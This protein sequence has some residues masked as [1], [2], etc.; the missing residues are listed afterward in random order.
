MICTADGKVYTYLNDINLT[1][2]LSINEVVKPTYSTDANGNLVLTFGGFSEKDSIFYE[3]SMY[4]ADNRMRKG[5]TG[6]TQGVGEIAL[7]ISGSDKRQLKGGSVLLTVNTRQ[8]ANGL[9][10]TIEQEQFYAPVDEPVTP[11]DPTEE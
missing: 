11:S 8:V 3:Y 6:S 7:R 10:M 9:T 2:D 4:D 1:V 5:G